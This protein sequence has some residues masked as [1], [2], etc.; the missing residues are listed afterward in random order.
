MWK[1]SESIYFPNKNPV[2]KVV[3]FTTSFPPY[4]Q[5]TVNNVLLTRCPQV[6]C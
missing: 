6:F 4:S 3:D 2:Y 5:N 1:S